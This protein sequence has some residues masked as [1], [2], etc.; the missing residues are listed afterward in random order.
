MRP[1]YSPIL[2][3]IALYCA[4]QC[5]TV[6]YCPFLSLPVLACPL[7]FT[8]LRCPLLSFPVV[9]CPIKFPALYCPFLALPVLACPIK[10]TVLSCPV[11]SYAPLCC[12]FLSLP[13]LYCPLLRRSPL[14]R[15]VC[16]R[17][18]FSHGKILTKSRSLGG[19]RLCIISPDK[20]TAQNWSPPVIPLCSGSANGG[21]SWQ[22]GSARR[23]KTKIFTILA[24]FSRLCSGALHSG[25][26][27]D[28]LGY[29]TSPYPKLSIYGRCATLRYKGGKI[30]PK[31]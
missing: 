13:A 15:S 2:P 9:A 17:C 27:I 22:I 1:L 28:S 5:S 6:L 10:F 11:R 16:R 24:E 3:Y 7:K 23:A 31:S 12:P 19:Q 14:R 4:L 18:A 8:A 29:G 26:K 20:A 21:V 25:H 30:P